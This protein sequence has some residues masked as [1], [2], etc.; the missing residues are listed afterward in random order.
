MQELSILSTYTLPLPIIRLVGDEKDGVPE[1][2]MYGE[3]QEA[4]HGIHFL[5]DLQRSQ[6]HLVQLR[7]RTSGRNN[8]A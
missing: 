6:L 7:A 2:E 8:L 3:F 5:N 4:I 1:F